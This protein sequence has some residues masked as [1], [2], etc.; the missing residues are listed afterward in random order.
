MLE[1]NDFGFPVLPKK[2]AKST[3]NSLGSKADGMDVPVN[4]KMQAL[5]GRGMGDCDLTT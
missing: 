3:R 1:Y 2:P 5:A 4:S